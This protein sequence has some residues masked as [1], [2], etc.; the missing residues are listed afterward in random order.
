MLRGG[1]VGDVD[2]EVQGIASGGKPLDGAGDAIAFCCQQG[3]GLGELC[4][5]STQGSSCAI[6]RLGTPAVKNC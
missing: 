1:V 4:P 3:E 6:V 5:V 2:D